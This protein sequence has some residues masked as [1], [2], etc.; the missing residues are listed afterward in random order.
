MRGG[1]GRRVWEVGVGGR[2]EGRKTEEGG[3]YLV[4]DFELF[5]L[6]VL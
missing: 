2:A 6:S 3:V 5:L 1:C 4:S